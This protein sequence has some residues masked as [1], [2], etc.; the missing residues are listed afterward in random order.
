M[1]NLRQNPLVDALGDVREQ[2]RR[3]RREEERLCGNLV[4]SGGGEGDRFVAVVR[5]SMRWRL[6]RRKLVARFGRAAVDE[7][8][9][10]HTD[11]EVVVHAIPGRAP[12]RL[13]P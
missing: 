7:C 10:P 12:L 11:V 6:V 13:G 4:L 5:R 3:L 8:C 1:E 9:K 2:I